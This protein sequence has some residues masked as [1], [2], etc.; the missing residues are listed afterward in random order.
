MRAPPR[1]RIFSWPVDQEKFWVS[2]PYGPRRRRDKSWEFHGGVDMAAMKVTPVFAAGPGVVEQAGWRGGYGNTILVR[3]DKTYKTRYAH[4]ATIKVYPGDSVDRTT[5]IGRVGDTG[6]VRSRGKD[7]SHLHY[8]VYVHGKR[9]N[10][11]HY[12]A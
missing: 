12:T 2:S 5:M 7:A 6:L 4:L 8:E 10:P 1:E 3:H 11:F 9:V